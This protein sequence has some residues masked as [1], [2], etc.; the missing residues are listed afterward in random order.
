MEQ[1][2]GFTDHESFGGYV[3]KEKTAAQQANQAMK[4]TVLLGL[5]QFDKCRCSSWATAV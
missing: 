3:Y 1:S 5:T 4:S 2:N